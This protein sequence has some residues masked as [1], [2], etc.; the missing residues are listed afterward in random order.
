MINTGYKIR[1]SPNLTVKQRSNGSVFVKNR[2]NKNSVVFDS[3]D[4]IEFLD[5]FN[6]SRLFD[7]SNG[8]EKYD[9]DT[10]E[11][12]IKFLDWG[13]L[14]VDLEL[15]YTP[16][17]ICG[18]KNT[19]QF[20]KKYR[21]EFDITFTYD[22]CEECSV[23]FL[24]PSP[25]ERALEF[26]Y[27]Y[28]GYYSKIDDQKKYK[29]EERITEKSNKIRDEIVSSHID[30]SKDTM[31]LDIGCGSG[32]FLNHM[33]RK[34][35]CNA[36]G[37]DVD[38]RAIKNIKIKNPQ[39]NTINGKFLNTE[40]DNKYDIITMWGYLEHEKRPKEVLEKASALLNNGG[41]LI[42]EIPNID[43]WTFRITKSKWPYLNPPLHLNHLCESVLK[44]LNILEDCRDIITFNN[45]T[46]SFMLKYS[47]LQ[48]YLY[49]I[50]NFSY[51][52]KEV[53]FVASVAFLLFSVFDGLFNKDELI[54][55]H[56]NEK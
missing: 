55:V 39:I 48:L 18:S 31:L 29:Y 37:I 53:D 7:P 51:R 47:K 6:K 20:V 9:E 26:F 46:G 52:S 10:N 41:V 38:T 50:V 24:N 44:R 28:Y 13:C 2:I 49:S 32:F 34:Y 27:K 15:E 3:N 35:K 12:I 43:S 30:V 8:N 1:K 21:K 33:E 17:P 22:K 54:I 23:V 56:Q 25:S 11:L 16:C 4:V 36:T 45:S 19:T 5:Y 42:I 40:K 14:T